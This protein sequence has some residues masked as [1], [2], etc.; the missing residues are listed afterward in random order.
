MKIENI[1]VGLGFVAAGKNR[2]HE[3]KFK[4][5][6]KVYPQML[7]LFF[8]NGGQHNTKVR[9]VSKNFSKIEDIF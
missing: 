3:Q 8:D 2:D 5:L 4:H 7:D 9:M 6:Q 1:L